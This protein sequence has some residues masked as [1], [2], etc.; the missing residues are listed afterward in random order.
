[1]NVSLTF[2]RRVGGIRVKELVRRIFFGLD[3]GSIVA[4]MRTR[5]V[6]SSAP[7]SSSSR[8]ARGCESWQSWCGPS[9]NPMFGY[10]SKRCRRSPLDRKRKGRGKL[11]KR[12]LLSLAATVIA[13]A[14]MATAVPAIAQTN[15]TTD[16]IKPPSFREGPF[17]AIQ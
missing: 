1:M 9:E 7:S 4:A 3:V 15:D 13:A 17:S 10:S 16:E 14:M 11:R 2:V 6:S 5:G 8:E 12:L